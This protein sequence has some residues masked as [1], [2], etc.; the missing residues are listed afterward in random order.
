MD[1]ST[2]EVDVL[3]IQ[4]SLCAPHLNAAALGM[5][6]ST[7]KSLGI[8][9]FKVTTM[10]PTSS[11]LGFLIVLSFCCAILTWHVGIED[12]SQLFPASLA[13]RCGHWQMLHLGEMTGAPSAQAF[14]RQRQ[15]SSFPILMPIWLEF[16]RW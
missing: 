13:A 4:L 7:H 9:H 15:A 1:K 11:R 6:P 8:L 5:N 16:R 3:M 10:A 12:R 2:R 14:H